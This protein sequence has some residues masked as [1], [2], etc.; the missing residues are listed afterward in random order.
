M[1]RPQQHP[2]IP[3]QAR[4]ISPR[5]HYLG[6]GP[7]LQ[8]VNIR[9]ALAAILQERA[10]TPQGRA[11]IP[12]QGLESIHLQGLGST[13]RQALAKYIPLEPAVN[14]HIP[15][16]Q[17]VLG[18]PTLQGRA[19]SLCILLVPSLRTRQLQEVSGLHMLRRAPSPHIPQVQ[20]QGGLSI[21]RRGPTPPTHQLQGVADLHIP[22]VQERGSLSI[23]HQEQTPPTH[24][25]QA[26]VSLP[27]LHRV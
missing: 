25:L 18:R 2:A 5:P 26:R 15:L 7:I 4:A 21:L 9:A 20:E 10:S 14:P 8:A 24:Q 13:R 11:L 19:V 16:G 6:W 3:Q 1:P 23:L 17:E 27:T 12:R 22:Q